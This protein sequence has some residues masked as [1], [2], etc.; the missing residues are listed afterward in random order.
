[1]STAL[2]FVATC[3]LVAH[4][5]GRSMARTSLIESGTGVGWTPANMALNAFGKI[6]DPNY[7]GSLGDLRLI[8][9]FET[10]IT[11]PG[12]G[13]DPT[14]LH[15]F[16]SNQVLPD[17]APWEFCPRTIAQNALRALHDEHG[18]EILA[19]FEHEFVLMGDGTKSGVPFGLD[20]YRMA[21][22]F[23]SQLYCELENAG[24][25]PENWLPEY[26]TGQFE[27]TLKPARAIVAA[28]RAIIAREIVRDCARRHGVRA[29]FAPLIPSAG[30]GNG[31]HVHLSMTKDG[32]PIT[33]DPSL[34][35]NL[36][37]EASIA[38]NGI[39][40]HAPSILA[41]T[42][43]SQISYLRLKPHQWSA[44]GIAIAIQ[45]REALLRICPVVTI[46]GNDPTASFNVEFRAADATANPWMVIAALAKGLAAGLADRKAPEKIIVGELENEDS[47]LPLPTSV[48]GALAALKADV[49]ARTWFSAA[50]M[51]THIQ[52][53]ESE[54]A[55]LA[56]L[57][58]AEKCEKYANVY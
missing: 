50:F 41:W 54:S 8:P 51:E 25:E 29:S 37:K 47:V 48:A 44:G 56:G 4:V 46:G 27:I 7:F 32:I 52:I 26:G 5:R 14:P 16:L 13:L 45:N 9:D 28:D 34:P 36:A 31:V 17:G 42:A 24:L 39:L 38:L 18:I 40:A 58:D 19:S 20:S 1:M 15:F 12:F 11:L 43:P 55:F 6:A 23:G 33:Y 53:R 3:D 57:D 10:E 21:E 22:P 2:A 30:V 35:G 49:V